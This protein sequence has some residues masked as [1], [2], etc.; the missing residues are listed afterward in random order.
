MVGVAGEDVVLD[1]AGKRLLATREAMREF[2]PGKYLL[3]WKPPSLD[4]NLIRPGAKGEVVVWLRRT[5]DRLEGNGGSG[6]GAA[7]EF[8]DPPLVS[9]IKDF[10][11]ERQL[12]PDGLVGEQTL[13][14]LAAESGDPSTPLLTHFAASAGD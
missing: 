4:V 5:L 11:R 8:Y 1:V 12:N 7:T 6:V 10:Q 14:Q 2:W 13:L 3:L 9:R